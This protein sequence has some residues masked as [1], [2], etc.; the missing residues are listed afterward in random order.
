MTEERFDRLVDEILDETR[1][2][3]IRKGI[4]Y[5]AASPDRLH[6]FKQAGKIENRIPE[7]VLISFMTKHIVSVYDLVDQLSNGSLAELHVW[8]EK[9]GDIRNYLILLEALVAE[10]FEDKKELF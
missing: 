4:E 7:Q 3:L 10:R 8:R 6:N 9:C 1:S 5:S 2:M